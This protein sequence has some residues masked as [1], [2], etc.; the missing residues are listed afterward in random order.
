VEGATAQRV[1][2]TARDRGKLGTAACLAAVALVAWPVQ[3]ITPRG[4]G[5]WSWIAALAYVA[6]HGLDFGDQLVW[7]FGPL[8]FLNTWGGPALYYDDVFTAAW[9]FAALIQLLLAGTLLV[10][11]RRSLPLGLA[12]LVGVVVLALASE[13]PTALGFAWCVLALTH[14]DDPPRDAAARWFPVAI[15]VLT[16]IG[17]LGK[18]NEGAGLLALAIIAL[19]AMPRRRDVLAFAGTLLATMLAGWLLS[20]QPLGGVWSYLRYSVEVVAGYAEAMGTSSSSLD[21][22][23][24]AAL[25]LCAL[26]LALAWTATR[27]ARPRRRWCLLALCAVYLAFHFKE[28]FVRQD[29][30]HLQV[31]FGG[32]LV[33]FAVLPLRPRLRPAALAGVVASVVALGVLIGGHGLLRAVDPVANVRAAADQLRTLVSP[34]RRAEIVADVRARAMAGYQFPAKLAA[35]VGRRSV[36]FWPFVY[37]EI[38]VA[39]D[40]NLRPLPTLEPY[41]A[42]TP[43]LDRLAGEMLASTRA[44]ERIVRALP[45]ASSAVDD[46][47]PSFE[48]PLATKQI[49]CRYRQLTV[50]EPWQ[51]LAR[52]PR[53]RCGSSRTLS[54]EWAAWGEPVLVPAPARSD[55]LL[56]V[57]IAGASPHGIERLKG[58]AVRSDERQISLDE[59]AFRLVSAT[60]DDGLLLSAPPG[61]DYRGSFAMAPN[62]NQIAVT[63]VGGQPGGELRYTFVEV[64][65]DAFPRAGR[66]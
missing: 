22:T 61:S 52:M 60:A 54:T 19:A 49:F 7:S 64:E 39:Y 1:L 29:R 20:G 3:S 13:R 48:A 47:Y 5:D 40:V 65:V 37:G 50:Q 31:F 46:R 59:T 30:T 9:L 34:T 17:V 56:L 55:A 6:H 16:G 14:G 23:Y 21:W 27:G 53:S 28:S 25:A 4:G 10:A 42:Y 33:L 62:P 58:L 51:V 43:T 45:A 18:L 41:A 24:V 26:A 11:L 35:V 36:M 2:T 15:G 32:A 44:P 8:G 38:V 57:K 63:R 66:E 12:M